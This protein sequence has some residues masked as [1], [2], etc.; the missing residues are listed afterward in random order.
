M[1]PS[2]DVPRRDRRAE[3]LIRKGERG[4]SAPCLPG[5]GQGADAP[6]SPR[7]A[8][9]EQT[10]TPARSAVP[11]S[12][13]AR[14][15][16]HDGLAIIGP[17]RP[18]PWAGAGSRGLRRSTDDDRSHAMTAAADRNLLFELLALQNGLIDQRQL[19]DERTFKTTL[20]AELS[21]PLS[22]KR[23]SEK[24]KMRLEHPGC[25]AQRPARPSA[26]AS[27]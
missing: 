24:K 11:R 7:T 4:A 9:L 23:T 18:D 16:M 13:P 26:P 12:P 20:C 8:L 3:S 1:R 19:T 14:M 6:R 5:S 2:D 21:P 27:L 15:Q 10:L 25:F 22:M 17:M